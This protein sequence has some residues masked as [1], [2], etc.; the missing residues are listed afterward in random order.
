MLDIGCRE[1]VATAVQKLEDVAPSHHRGNI[2]RDEPPRGRYGALA[3]KMRSE[4]FI[5]PTGAHGLPPSISRCTAADGSFTEAL[6]SRLVFNLD[7]G[8][9]ELLTGGWILAQRP[10]PVDLRLARQ[11]GPLAAIL[12]CL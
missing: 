1:P 12:V 5:E 6:A 3:S 10:V 11:P 2:S 7:D 8:R 9:I 4:D